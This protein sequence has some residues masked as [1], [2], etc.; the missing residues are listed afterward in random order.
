MS[1]IRKTIV[2]ILL[3]ELNGNNF[4][5]IQ[6]TVAL[7]FVRKLTEKSSDLD[8]DKSATVKVSG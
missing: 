7:L 5:T 4:Y 6:L 8:S 3:D 1:L 2:V